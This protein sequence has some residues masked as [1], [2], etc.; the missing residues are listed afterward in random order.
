MAYL[1]Y[2]II[3]CTDTFKSMHVGRDELEHWH[4][5]PKSNK[6]GTITYFGKNYPDLQSAPIK[7]I[8]RGKWGNGWSRLGY[9]KIFHRDGLITQ[10]VPIDDDQ[11]ISS[12]EVT[13]GAAGINYKAVHVVLEGGRLYNGKR[14]KKLIDFHDLFTV[15][16]YF[17]LGRD[18]Q[19]FLIDHPQVKIGGHNQFSSKLCPGFDVKDMATNMGFKNYIVT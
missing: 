12:S 11:Y 17:N 15:D 2:Y 5:A 9:S 8:H 6:D 19:E 13:W 4:R 16:Q 1:E 14:A 7:D 10:L 3:H 18:I